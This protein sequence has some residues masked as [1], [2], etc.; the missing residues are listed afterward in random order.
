MVEDDSSTNPFCRKGGQSLM[1]S[2]IQQHPS[3]KD[4]LMQH[5][6]N[7]RFRFNDGDFLKHMAYPEVKVESHRTI[8]VQL[9]NK[10]YTEQVTFDRDFRQI[11]WVSYR[12]NFA[13][14][15]R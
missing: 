8:K 2:A 15:I 10:V 12:K 14:L 11:I 1:L 7:L 6:T 5:L 3:F 4:N 13:P 9:L